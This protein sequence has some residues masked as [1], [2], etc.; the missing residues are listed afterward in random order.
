[1]PFSFLISSYVFSWNYYIHTVIAQI[2]YD[3]LP[4]QK[5][6]VIEELANHIFTQLPQK[7]Q[8]KLN[9]FYSGVSTFAKTSALPDAWRSW[10]F[11]TLFKNFTSIEPTDF[12]EFSPQITHDWHFIDIPY[13]H[14]S[15]PPIA[16]NNNVVWAITTLQKD[17]PNITDQNTKAV[18]L[19][20][21]SHFIGDIHQPLHAINNVMKSCDGDHG[22]NNFCLQ[23]RN[24]ICKKNLHALWDEGV[25]YFNYRENVLAVSLKLQA[26]YPRKTFTQPLLEWN[27]EKWAE[28]SYAFAAKVYH[29]PEEQIPSAAY[30][31]QSKAIAA[32]Q[33]T[34]AGYRLAEFI[35]RYF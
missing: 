24:G 5:K 30:F 23:R 20:M 7:E 4:L 1:M 6:R 31:K 9:Q 34:L 19:I 26:L 13:P 14:N 3:Q 29:T 17:L 32:Y 25:D 15:C 10:S 8:N 28:E 2:A 22:G 11:I 16:S 12:I 21:L 33:V 35:N 27:Q 18:F